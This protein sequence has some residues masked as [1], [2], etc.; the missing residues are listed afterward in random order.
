MQK[1]V[2]VVISHYD[3][4]EQDVEC[5]CSSIEDATKICRYLNEKCATPEILNDKYD[6]DLPDDYDWLGH[7]KYYD[8][9]EF[10]TTDAEHY[11]LTHPFAT[12]ANNKE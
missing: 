5:V 9:L 7:E 1:S 4:F 12:K 11:K 10:I 8:W 2:F 6:Y 3:A